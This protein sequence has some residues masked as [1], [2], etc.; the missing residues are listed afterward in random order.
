MAEPQERPTEDQT[1]IAP[2]L[3]QSTA[4]DFPFSADSNVDVTTNANELVERLQGSQLSNLG[5]SE[6]GGQIEQENT[7]ELFQGIE[8]PAQLPPARTSTPIPHVDLGE[9]ASDLTCDGDDFAAITCGSL[10]N[11]GF[12]NHIFTNWKQNFFFKQ[13]EVF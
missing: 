10:R 13:M 12:G 3:V 8:F 7:I 5:I 1:L 6:E 9:T 4:V 2:S 11:I